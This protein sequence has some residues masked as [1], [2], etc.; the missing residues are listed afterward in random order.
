MK[1][2]NCMKK[3][4]VLIFL[5]VFL[6]TFCS[7]FATAGEVKATIWAGNSPDG[8]AGWVWTRTVGDEVHVTFYPQNGWELAEI[9]I[10]IHPFKCQIPQTGNPCVTG[11]PGNPK[12]GHFMRGVEFDEPIESG[13]SYLVRIPLSEIGAFSATVFVA[14][15]VVVIQRENGVVVEEETGWVG[16]CVS[17]GWEPGDGTPPFPFEEVWKSRW[18]WCFVLTL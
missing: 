10:A 16:P 5:G 4:L 14:I 18:G 3:S 1:R 17:T 7:S 9:H 13:S 6:V 15:H 8:N 11:K 2:R 12:I